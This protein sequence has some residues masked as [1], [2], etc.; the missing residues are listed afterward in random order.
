MGKKKQ[1]ELTFYQKE[2]KIKPK[3]FKSLFWIVFSMVAASFIAFVIVLVFGTR[4][5]VIGEG[6]EPTLYNSQMVLINKASYILF[7]PKSGDIVA[8]YPNGNKKAHYYLKRVVA[9]PGDRVVIKD[10][11]LYVN[12][13][14][15]KDEAQYDY[16][17]FAGLAQNELTL[18]KNE[19]FIL[20]DNRNSSEDSRD[21][22]IGPVNKNQIDGRVWFHFKC[23]QA[24]MGFN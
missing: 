6:M 11:H 23:E 8:F 24:D 13:E 3:H 14:I 19:F 20:G 4:T 9:V 18:Q 2:K 21:G 16:I 7:P 1:H 10:G 17:E 12:D 15:Y 22:N 5:T